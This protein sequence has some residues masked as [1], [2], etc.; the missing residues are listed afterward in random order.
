MLMSSAATPAKLQYMSYS[1]RVLVP[2]SFV[3][4]AETGAVIALEDLRY[5]SIDR[6]E[7]Y[8]DA[9]ASTRA[10]ARARRASGLPD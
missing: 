8:I 3:L 5:W 7:P 10:E 1:F 4:C 9:D 6:Q 2:G